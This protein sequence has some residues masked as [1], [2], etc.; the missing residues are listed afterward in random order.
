M[1]WKSPSEDIA[2]VAQTATA[3]AVAVAVAMVMAIA[4]ANQLNGRRSYY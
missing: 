2:F 4:T 3:A 1:A